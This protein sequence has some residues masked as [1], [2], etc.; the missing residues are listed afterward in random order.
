MLTA[1]NSL[2]ALSA[3][4][5]EL[6]IQ[7]TI[8]FSDSVTGVYRPVIAAVMNHERGSYLRT[9]RDLW[10][11]TQ[12]VTQHSDDRVFVSLHYF[13]GLLEMAEAGPHSRELDDVL[14][15]AITTAASFVADYR[16]LLETHSW[17]TPEQ[18]ALFDKVSRERVKYALSVLDLLVAV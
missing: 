16:A 1:R 9:L 17:M 15:T 14:R 13:N 3:N 2:D 18:L 7:A 12:Q 4:I 5:T 10:L 6:R 11:S 8:R